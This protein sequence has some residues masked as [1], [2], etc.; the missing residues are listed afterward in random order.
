MTEPS[1]A[2]AKNQRTNA[3]TNL[4]SVECHLTRQFMALILL[5]M[6]TQ[7]VTLDM[8]AERVG[9]TRHEVEKMLIRGVQ[10]HG[11]INTTE[12]AV[13]ACA[14]GC[15][16]KVNAQRLDDTIPETNEGI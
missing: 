9:C 4:S 12:L 5:E 16:F 14:L 13:L 15:F 6:A 10:G 1:K 8:L 7:R 3:E 11:D 2:K